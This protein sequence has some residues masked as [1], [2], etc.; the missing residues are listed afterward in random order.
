MK[1]IIFFVLITT[2]Y[3][4]DAVLSDI[5]LVKT[6][7][8]DDYPQTTVGAALDN[9]QECSASGWESFELANGTKFVNFNCSINVQEYVQGAP[10]DSC[11][12]TMQSWALSDFSFFPYMVMCA[13]VDNEKVQLV[14][15]RVSA[16]LQMQFQVN[17][18]DTFQ[19]TRTAL[20]DSSGVEM[21][22]PIF[23]DLLDVIYADNQLSDEAY[24]LIV[25][26]LALGL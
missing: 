21:R 2:L 11:I 6:G 7:I 13:Q 9:W 1:R 22:S 12:T 4:C 15:S 18:D 19:F 16:N 26:L 24:N 8:L 20:L 23:P 25:Y 10:F 5:E 14:S 17:L 3:G